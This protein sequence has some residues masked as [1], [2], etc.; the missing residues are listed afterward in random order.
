MTAIH[1]DHYTI[2][3]ISFIIPIHC[4]YSTLDENVMVEHLQ[5]LHLLLELTDNPVGMEC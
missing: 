5:K 1:N 4:Y 2:I 3:I